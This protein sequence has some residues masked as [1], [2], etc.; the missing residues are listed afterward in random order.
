[1]VDPFAGGPRSKC[2]SLASA[3]NRLISEVISQSFKE[4]KVSDRFDIGV[5][6]Y[7]SDKQGS[8]V[9]GPALKGVLAGRDLVTIPELEENFLRQEERMTKQYDAD[10]GRVIEVPINF[11]VWYEPPPKDEMLGTPMCAALEYVHRIASSWCRDHAKSF[12]PI[13]IHLTDGESTDGDPE[14]TSEALRSEETE[15]GNLLLFNCHLSDSKEDGVLFP[16]NESQ[17]PT[18]FSKLLFRMSSELPDPMLKMAEVKQAS[19]APGSRGMAFNADGVAMV[20]LI[21]VGTDTGGGDVRS[22][23]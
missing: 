18:D 5:I 20:T 14:A 3:I 9:I 8:P 13:V 16:T 15:E 7:T 11:V 4:D 21:N 1:M 2:D 22:L 12:P 17:L 23:R 10:A 6:G 19:V